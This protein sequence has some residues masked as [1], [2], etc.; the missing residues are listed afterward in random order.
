MIESQDVKEDDEAS[1]EANSFIR[2]IRYC[3]AC[4]VCRGILI[5]EV[6]N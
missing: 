2:L 3:G 1:I 4:L 6:F 5:A